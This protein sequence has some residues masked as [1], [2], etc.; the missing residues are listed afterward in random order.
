MTVVERLKRGRC[1]RG[2]EFV[3]LFYFSFRGI[4]RMW[5]SVGFFGFDVGFE[6][7]VGEFRVG[8]FWKDV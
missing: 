8:F 3:V 2:F 5:S 4:G 6:S 1:S 7:G